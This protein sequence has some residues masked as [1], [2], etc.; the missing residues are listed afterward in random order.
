MQFMCTQLWS[1]DRLRGTTT[2]PSYVVRVI[3]MNRSG[4]PHSPHM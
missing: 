3:I 1:V 4:D 2:Q